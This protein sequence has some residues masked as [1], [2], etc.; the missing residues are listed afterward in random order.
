MGPGQVIALA[1]LELSHV[2]SEINL[3]IGLPSATRTPQ[4]GEA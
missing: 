2:S 3:G 1:G 4:R